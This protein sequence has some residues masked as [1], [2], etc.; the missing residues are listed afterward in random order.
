VRLLAIVCLAGLV[1]GTA[2][3]ER[4]AVGY[5]NGKRF[6]LKIVDVGWAEV[7]VKTARAFEKMR[8]AARADGVRLVIWSGFRT[9]ERQAE[10]Y[11]AWR[12]KEGNL[13][14][15]PGYSNHQSGRALDLMLQEDG[16]YEWLKAHAAK[17]GFRRTVKGEPWH[18]EFFGTPRRH[19]RR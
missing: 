3:A 1:A 4:T 11:R 10:L 14:A 6:K 9:Y 19:R 15:R 12:K 18:W 8:D 7:E 16:V 5:A 17:F 2:H 13:A